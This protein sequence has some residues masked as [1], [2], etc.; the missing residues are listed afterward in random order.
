MNADPACLECGTSVPLP[1]FVA[2]GMHL[3]CP[4]CGEVLAVKSLEP[5]EF[6]SPTT[7]ESDVWPEDGDSLGD[8]LWVDSDRK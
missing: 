6:E 1:E 8:P 2:L 3:A 5:F 7:L 4:A